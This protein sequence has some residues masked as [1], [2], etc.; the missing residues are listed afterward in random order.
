MDDML[1]VDLTCAG[2]TKQFQMDPRTPFDAEYDVMEMKA[3]QLF[4]IPDKYRVT[5]VADPNSYSRRKDVDN[6]LAEKY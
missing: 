2:V 3:R 4:K 1:R 6:V 5:P